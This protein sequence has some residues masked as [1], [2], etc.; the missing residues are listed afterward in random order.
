MRVAIISVLC[1]G[2]LLFSCKGD[3]KHLIARTWHVV[4]WENPYNDSFFTNAQAYIDTMG[5]GHDDATNIA[6]YGVANMD[7]MRH[8]LQA[9]YDSAK[10]IQTKAANETLFNFR[11]DGIAEVTIDGKVN[12]GKWI[13]DDA[14][15]LILEETGF[16]NPAGISKYNIVSLTEQQLVLRF[17]GENDSST[18]T[19]KA[20]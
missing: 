6:L 8:I 9:Q 7:S 17:Y 16:G 14:N 5:K 11:K 19:F 18:V 1:C 20:N 2:A 4:K 10:A 3:R 13:M 15:G 12:T